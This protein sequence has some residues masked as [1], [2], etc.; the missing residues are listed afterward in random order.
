MHM[1]RARLGSALVGTVIAA[2]GAMALTAP[3]H[4]AVITNA[5]TSI[6]VLDTQV[7]S[8]GIV[9]V[10]FAY[11]VPDG[12]KAGDTFTITMSDNVMMKQGQKFALLAPDG[13]VVARALVVGQK[14][15]F[16]MTSYSEE[17][18]G[19]GGTGHLG[20]RFDADAVEK[21]GTQNVVLHSGPVV[22]SGEVKILVPVATHDARKWMTWVASPGSKGYPDQDNLIWRVVSETITP[23]M[24]GQRLALVDAGGTGIVLDCSTISLSVGKFFPSGQFSVTGPYTGPVL[25]ST[26]DSTEALRR[27]TVTDDLV[28]SSLVLSGAASAPDEDQTTFT[29]S[30]RQVLAGHATPVHATAQTSSG[31]GDGVGYKR[32]CVGDYVW[33]DKDAD[34]VQDADEVGIAGVTLR[35][36]GPDGAPVKDVDGNPVTSTTTDSTGH[37]SFCRLPVLPAGQHYTVT[38]TPPAGFRQTSPTGIHSTSRESGDLTANGASDLTL[39][40]GFVRESV[41]P[42]PTPSTPTP[43]PTPTPAAPRPPAATPTQTPVLAHTGADGALGNVA[44]GLLGI[45]AGTGLIASGRPRRQH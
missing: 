5:V 21:G 29:N 30:G 44:L 17:H 11:K 22:G 23:E 24:V 10:S 15:V 38:V 1:L 40:F 41:S 42:S 31:A 12:T 37:Y 3:A 7:H 28:G 2:S 45:L 34:G 33:L 6:S 9:D 18:Y 36:V 27:I 35:I 19:V 25:S 14:I 16:T 43:G 39:D 32:V 8:S 13:Q 26:C 4:A 20:L